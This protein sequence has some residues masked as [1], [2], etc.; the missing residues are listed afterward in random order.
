MGVTLNAV[1]FVP[2]AGRVKFPG[3]LISTIDPVSRACEVWNETIIVVT[4]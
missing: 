2:F 4:V 1:N 3:I